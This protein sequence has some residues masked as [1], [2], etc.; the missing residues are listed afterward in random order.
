[1][2]RVQFDLIERKDPAVVI[3]SRRREIFI[4]VWLKRKISHF[5]RDDTSWIILDCDMVPTQ[6][7]NAGQ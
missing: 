4:R 1:M 3:S 6:S 7:K 5:V 2:T